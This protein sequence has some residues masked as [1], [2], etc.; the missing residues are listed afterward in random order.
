[1]VYTL[2]TLYTLKPELCVLVQLGRGH[3]G[4]SHPGHPRLS[5]FRLHIMAPH[6]VV[7]EP[8]F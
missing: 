5:R 8:G 4:R 6:N 3:L 2:Y 7:H 1:M